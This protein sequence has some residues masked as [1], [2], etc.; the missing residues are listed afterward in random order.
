MLRL[1]LTPR[2]VGWTALALLAVA[3]CGGMAYWQLL[4]AESPEGSLLNAGYA[5]QWPL[6]G[7]FFAAL[8]WR[9]LRAEARV[10]DEI[11]G[12]RERHTPVVAAPAGSPFGPRPAGVVAGGTDAEAAPGSGRAEY[13]AMLAAL[14]QTPEERD[15]S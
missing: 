10:L 1:V 7:V 8:W 6:F 5:A 15:P 11:V 3:V 4:R 9:M 12:R 14:A 13:N 2:W